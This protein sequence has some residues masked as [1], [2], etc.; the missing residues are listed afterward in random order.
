MYE[1]KYKNYK[2]V[3]EKQLENF[4]NN[5]E[6]EPLL[7][8]AMSYSLLQGGKRLRP[9]L[10]LS[11]NELLGGDINECLPL[12]ASI[13]MIHTYSLI[14]D[15]L[16]A[17]DN[18]DYRRGKLTNHKIYG[19]DMAV[20]AGDGLLNYAFEKL[21]DNALVYPQ[22]ISNHLKA[23]DHI[24]K[25]AGAEGMISG[26]SLDLN[27][28]GTLVNEEFIESIHK[29]KTAALIIGSLKAG[30]QLADPTEAQLEAIESFGYNFG[31]AFQIIDDILDITQDSKTLGKDTNKDTENDKRTFPDIYGLEKSRD[32]AKHL[33]KKAIKSLDIFG[34]KALFLKELSL[35]YLNREY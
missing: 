10:A 5:K 28:I 9:V 11:A 34:E 23:I 15:D 4:L 29:K 31:L 25:A 8:E 6:I 1:E 33:S 20:L 16:P 13:E 7:N 2:N 17:M 19:D 21:L 30:I 14:H 32:T 26:Q 12:A 3:I 18:S 22:N 24:A 35:T 27:K